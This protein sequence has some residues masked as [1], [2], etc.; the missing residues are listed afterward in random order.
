TLV[1][2]GGPVDLPV[3][4]RNS[5]GTATGPVL[6]RLALPTGITAT[7]GGVVSREA[8]G[9]PGTT[10]H[11]APGTPAQGAPGATAQGVTCTG[12]TGSISCS[13]TE[14]LAAGQQVAFTFTLVAGPQAVS[15]SVT[16]TV[17]AG[18]TST[19][20]TP[21]RV[22]VAS[23]DAVTLTVT[24]FQQGTFQTHLDI[25]A[26]N[27][28]QTTR[29]VTVTAPLPPNV[30]VSTFMGQCTPT[31]TTLACTA[32]LA[33]GQEAFWHTRLFALADV[34]AEMRFT[35]TLGTATA[36]ATVRIV[37]QGLCPGDC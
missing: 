11:G 27:T 9:A 34:D 7:G 5:G 8:Q 16:G 2:G 12:G 14:G 35:A 31:T 6:V 4:V 21:V 37:L 23:T 30:R 10:A 13:T 1:A 29:T 28:G 33:P 18:G 15:G 36:T 32:T 17:E 25:R 26:R 20:L 22:V 19:P 3:L 24:P